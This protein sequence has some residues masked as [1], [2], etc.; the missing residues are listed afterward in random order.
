MQTWLTNSAS[1]CARVLGN[2]RR[3]FENELE[4]RMTTM[5]VHRLDGGAVSL[6]YDFH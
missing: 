4:V 2:G 1:R 3:L 6:R 5:N